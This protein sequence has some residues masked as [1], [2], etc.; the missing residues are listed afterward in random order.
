MA[1]RIAQGR[2]IC[3]TENNATS[4]KKIGRLWWYMVATLFNTSFTSL[5]IFGTAFIFFLDELGLDKARIGILLA[6]IPF[7]GVVAPLAASWVGR[8]GLKHTFILFWG[9]RKVVFALILLVPLI[10][11]RWGANAT[12]V[13]VAG[14]V[15]AFSLCRAIAETGFYPWLQELIPNAI[16]G[17]FNAINSVIST[18]AS[19]AAAAVSSYVIDSMTGIGR[20]ML[21]FGVGL[22]FGILAVISYARLPGGA[23]VHN[24]DPQTSRTKEMRL[25]LHDSAYMSFLLILAVVALGGSIGG[26]FV[27]LYANEQIGLSTGNVVLLSI[28]ASIGGLISSYPLGWA[29]DRYGS[30]PMMVLGLLFNLIG[31]L[32]WLVMPRHSA[33]SLPFAMVL[34]FLAT[35]SNTAWATGSNRYFYNT[36]VPPQKRTG[37]M[38]VWY[39][40]TAIVGGSG[41]LIAGWLL[42]WLNNLHGQFMGFAID[43]YTPLF[44]INAAFL[45]A[46]M[47]L[48]ARVPDDEAIPMRQMLGQLLGLEPGGLRYP[49]HLRIKADRQPGQTGTTQSK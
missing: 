14:I 5:T 25:A 18:L 38:A 34:Q 22:F 47:L 15:M 27:S 16:R 48:A 36:A 40:W 11:S 6:L 41:P 20:Y 4:V 17:K 8:F 42:Q 24:V 35:V 3:M 43:S 2:A 12:F 28:G 1:L 39:A 23:P 44:L 37:Y 7:A 21:L 49:R 45:V 33:V 13:W 30:R 46:G 19:M 32:G 31:P 29:S 9:L 26:A 10:L